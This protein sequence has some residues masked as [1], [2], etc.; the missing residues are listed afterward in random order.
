MVMLSKGIYSADELNPRPK[1]GTQLDTELNMKSMM[2][3]CYAYSSI[4]KNS[5]S[6]IQYILPYKAKLDVFGTDLFE[7]VYEDQAKNLSKM[8]VLRNTYTDSEGL[9]YN[10]LVKNDE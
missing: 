7:L 5:D 4:E 6:Y 2:I 9:T 1:F 3:S 8:K 10:T